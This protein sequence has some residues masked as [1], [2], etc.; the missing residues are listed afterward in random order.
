MLD[1]KL[2]VGIIV[3]LGLSIQPGNAALLVNGDFES[4][5]GSS[6]SPISS[7]TITG[8]TFS[9]DEYLIYNQSGY[10]G[11]ITAQSGDFYISLGHNGTT[12]GTLSQSFSTTVG[13]SY[14]VSYYTSEQQGSATD[15]QVVVSV[16]GSDPNVALASQTT[17]IIDSIGVW[18][19]NSFTFIAD[20][21]STT[22]Q[23]F[24]ATLVGGGANWALDTVSVTDGVPEPSTWAMMILGFAGIG[25]MAYRRTS[26][27]AL[28]MQIS[29]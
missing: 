14:L 5:G 21:T 10:N 25:F 8:W 20:S 23:F 9:G 4:P 7:S 17:Q 28:T 19:L 12:G 26:A 15:Q 6:V 18:N 2:F 16:F 13:Q 3:A 1:K 11:G 27:S 29:A 22:L 24:D